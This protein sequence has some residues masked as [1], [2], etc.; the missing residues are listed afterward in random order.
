[1]PLALGLGLVLV[2]IV[3]LINAAAQIIKSAAVRRYG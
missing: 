1:L 3:F 2:A